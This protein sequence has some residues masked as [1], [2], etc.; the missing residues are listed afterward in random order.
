MR[1]LL[2]DG[3]ARVCSALD[4]LLRSDPEIE[5]VGKSRNFDD[6]LK[7][8]RRTAPDLIL[9]DWELPGLPTESL[10]PSWA[11]SGFRPKVVIL[12]MRPES[13]S[14]ALAAGADAFVSKSYPP[15]HLMDA[16]KQLTGRA[17]EPR[18]EDSRDEP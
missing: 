11:A 7:Q 5:L 3:D 12:G 2:A 18:G 16:L 9:L 15:S 10:W 4:R 17:T 14:A 6:V 13:E 8:A 1:I